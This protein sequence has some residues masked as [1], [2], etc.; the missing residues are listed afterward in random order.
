MKINWYVSTK[1]GDGVPAG[2]IIISAGTAPTNYL[3]CDGSAVSRTTYS[4][5]FSAIAENYGEGDG[6]STFNLPDLSWQ[7]SDLRR[8]RE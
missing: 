6:S 3:L 4:A 2:T 1:E 5:L 8:L 7:G